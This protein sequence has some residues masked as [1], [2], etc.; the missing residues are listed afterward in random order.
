MRKIVSEM[1]KIIERQLKEN[2]L[3]G[4]KHAFPILPTVFQRV[5]D[6]QTRQKVVRLSTWRCFGQ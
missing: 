4:E 6:G 2:P 5:L 1:K 3:T